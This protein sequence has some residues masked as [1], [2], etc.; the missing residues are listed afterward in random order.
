MQTGGKVKKKTRNETNGQ[1]SFH[2]L[3]PSG[4]SFFH[5]GL[6]KGTHQQ[7]SDFCVKNLSINKRDETQTLLSIFH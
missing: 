4:D 7:R 2:W 5:D 3:R 1:H 6:R